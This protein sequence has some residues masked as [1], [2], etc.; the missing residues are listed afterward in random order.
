MSQNMQITPNKN[1]D[2]IQGQD[3]QLRDCWKTLL[4]EEFQKP[5]MLELKK[6]LKKEKAA[7]KIIYPP[8]PLIF[9][10]LNTT[11]FED[12]KVVILGQDP[13]HGPNQAHGLSFSVK[14]GIPKPPSLVNIFKEIHS[15]L[16]LPIPNY[17]DLTSWAEQGV[18]LLNATLTVQQAHANSHQGKGWDIF[19]DK[20][21]SVL[22]DNREN[23]VFLLWGSFAQKKGQFID[24]KKHLVLEAPHPS[25][26]SSHRGF[27]G[28]KHFSKT[29]KYL[30]SKKIKPIDW[31]LPQLS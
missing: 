4:L 10:A 19:T 15:D 30:E 9:N 21:I 27:F 5:Y 24:R 14:K 26:L 18:L 2:Q 25:P 28:C 31:S 3:V 7:K 1:S 17:G 11:G 29:N 23:I 22:N 13:Y 6:F 8:G 12:V 20:V 16:K